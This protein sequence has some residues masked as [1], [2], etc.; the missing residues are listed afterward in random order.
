MSPADFQHLGSG[1]FKVKG[2]QL[3][4][5]HSSSPEQIERRHNSPSP[6]T[7]KKARKCHHKTHTKK[8]PKASS[9]SKEYSSDKSDFDGDVDS[10]MPSESPLAYSPSEELDFYYNDDMLI[11]D[12]PKQKKKTKKCE[13]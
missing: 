9:K 6:E 1:C 2:K 11:P 8:K 3:K 4:R 12:S 7:V 5:R 10:D 13:T